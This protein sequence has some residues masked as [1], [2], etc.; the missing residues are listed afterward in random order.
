MGKFISLE[1][2]NEMKKYE[3]AVQKIKLAQSNL[4][5]VMKIAFQNFDFVY[6]ITGMY[7]R[8]EE[9]SPLDCDGI[10]EM[11]GELELMLSTMGDQLGDMMSDTRHCLENSTKQL[12]P[13]LTQFNQ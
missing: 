4:V 7:R 5:E 8:P 9:V 6:Q 3:F 10:Y 12:I 1:T 2:L 11:K 13:A